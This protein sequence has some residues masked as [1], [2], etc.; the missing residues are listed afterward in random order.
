MGLLGP[1]PSSGR[2]HAHAKF[3]GLAKKLPAIGTKKTF[4]FWKIF[5]K[6]KKYEVAHEIAH[7]LVY[8][9]MGYN[10]LLNQEA[11]PKSK[12]GVCRPPIFC[13][14]SILLK[15]FG[16]GKHLKLVYS[17]F[18]DQTTLESVIKSKDWI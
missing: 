5:E 12:M 4:L 10:H 17:K 16:S 8:S 11:V 9:F 13:R 18:T 14:K 6:F 2:S 15:I 3:S 7:L 1:A